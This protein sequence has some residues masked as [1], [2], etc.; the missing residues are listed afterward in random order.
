MSDNNSLFSDFNIISDSEWRTKVIEDLKGKNFEESLVWEDESGIK[1]QPYYRKSSIESKE[2][3]TKIQRAQQKPIGWKFVQQFPLG[4]KDLE[5][6]VRSAHESGVDEIVIRD[7]E[8]YKETRTKFYKDLKEIEHIHLHLTK[9]DSHAPP[10]LIFCDPIAEAVKLGRVDELEMDALKVLFQK[11]LNQLNPDNFLK[12][13]GSIYK[14][15]GASIIEELAYTLHHAVEYMDQLTEAGFRADAIARSFT[16]KLGFGTSF[17]SEIAKTRAFRYLIQKIYQSYNIEAKVRIWG[18]ASP[19]YHSDKDPYNN[20]VRLTTQCMSAVIGNC[21]LIELPAF[22]AWESSSLLGNRTSKNISLILKEESYFNQVHDLSEGSY[23][24]EWLSNEIAEKTWKKF[25]DIEK[26]GGLI[27][28][29]K[30]GS[31]AKELE[32]TSSER[33]LNYKEGK[34]TMV[35]VNKYE[36]KDAVNLKVKDEVNKLSSSSLLSKAIMK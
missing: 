13:D 2:N 5:K 10:K 20:L 34:R 4:L 22:D 7:I 19:F 17:F 11:R 16:F 6:K 3:V 21:D 30:D 23:Y 32:K 15:A 35:G 8:N 27:P 9:I 12:V 1:H 26:E 25:L 14:N 18:E 29:I 24:I 36:N 33:V 28:K 31:L